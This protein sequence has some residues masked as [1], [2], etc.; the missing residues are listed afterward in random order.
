MQLLEEGPI[1]KP[2]LVEP[3]ERRR[4]VAVFEKRGLLM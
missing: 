3:R 4:E 2:R 1:A